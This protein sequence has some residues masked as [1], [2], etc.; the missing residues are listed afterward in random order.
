MGKWLTPNDPQGAALCRPLTIPA[1]FIHVVSGA[2]E[3]LAAEW[4]W[5]AHGSLTPAES[6]AIMRQM[7]DD[8]YLAECEAAMTYPAFAQVFWRDMT[9]VSGNALNLEQ[10]DL[11]IFNF[12]CE[13]S[14][15]AAGNTVEANILI[16]AGSYIVQSI[17]C[18]TVDGTTQTVFVDG[19]E[20]GTM[21]WAG[22]VVW[23]TVKATSPFAIAADGEHTV[24]FT[25]AASGGKY[26]AKMT[27]FVVKPSA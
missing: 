14:P 2:L 27:R 1:E 5:E 6:A 10:H 9:V 22:T 26:Q 13:Q 12:T 23:N 25:A 7:I 15:A 3:E 24:R 17:G 4:N 19:V 20:V 21:A 11:Q 18:R 16:R 8:W